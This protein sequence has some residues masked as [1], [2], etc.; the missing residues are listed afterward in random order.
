MKFIEFQKLI[1]KF[2]KGGRSIFMKKAIISVLIIL[3]V[4]IVGFVSANH[5]QG[6]PDPVQ[7]EEI[8]AR[9]IIYGSTSDEPLIR[10][11]FIIHKGWNLIPNPDGDTYNTGEPT[12][13]I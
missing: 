13:V 11:I 2:L 4:G 6:E 9:D 8:K 12:N 7:N 3:M 1:G 5:V 10:S